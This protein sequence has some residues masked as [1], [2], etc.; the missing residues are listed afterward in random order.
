MP[1]AARVVL[2]T[3]PARGARRFARG[4]VERR[5]AACVQLVPIV[6]LYAWRGKLEEAREVLLSIKTT[7]ACA[8]ALERHVRA[9]HPY[10]VPEFVVV[11]CEH[12][13][14]RYLAWLRDETQA[15][16]FRGR[17]ARARR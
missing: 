4:L 17:H 1:T 8:K 10:E 6:S 16:P 3:H 12:V 11:A 5:L 13:E 15:A 2:L 9:T 14:R 7:A